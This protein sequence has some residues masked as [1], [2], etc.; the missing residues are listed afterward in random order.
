MRDSKELKKNNTK[1]NSSMKNKAY[2][3]R[4]KD[5]SDRAKRFKKIVV[6]IATQISN[7]N[8]SEDEE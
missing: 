8:S 7:D 2:L 1:N 5:N 6:V 3:S 4:N